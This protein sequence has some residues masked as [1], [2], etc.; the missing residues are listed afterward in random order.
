MIG[1]AAQ[2]GCFYRVKISKK[3]CNLKSARSNFILGLRYHLTNEFSSFL[4]LLNY[5]EHHNLPKIPPDLGQ[6]KI[7]AGLR[8]QGKLLHLMIAGTTFGNLDPKLGFFIEKKCL[9]ENFYVFL[10]T[11]LISSMHTKYGWVT[12]KTQKVMMLFRS[13]IENNSNHSFSN[14]LR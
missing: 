10:K 14:F 2:T 1:F 7:L 11:S 9:I 3:F 8:H 13:K 6:Q 4:V 5:Q 12:P